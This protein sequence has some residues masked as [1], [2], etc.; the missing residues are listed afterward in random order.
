MEKQIE[1][2]KKNVILDEKRISLDNRKP[3]KGY[4]FNNGIDFSA[5]MR[6][7]ETMGIQSSNMFKAVELIN[8]M[9]AWRGEEGEKCKIYLGYTSNMA[10]SGMREIIRYLCEHSLVDAIVT[11]TGGVEEDF[12]KCL[13]DHLVGEFPEDDRE[14]RKQGINR[15]GNMYVPNV[16]YCYFEDWITPLLDS[17]WTEQKETG[18]NWTPSKMIDFLG[19]NINNK[20]SI[21]YWCHKNKIPVYCPGLTD[22]S[23]GDMLF[24]HSYKKPGL[25]IDVVEDIRKI[26]SSAIFAKQTGAIILGGGIVK[27]H[28]MNANLMRNGADFTVLINTAIEYDC[29][30]AGAKPTEALSWGKIKS[31]GEFVKIYSEASLVFPFIVAE[32][33]AREVEKRKS[34]GK[35]G[36]AKD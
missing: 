17:M 31:S 22:G 2:A 32:T 18:I 23:I 28:I 10:S 35:A 25:I 1:D 14:L 29:S 36:E 20:D 13:A 3:V 8:K 21:Y 12:M 33:F 26:N 16:N 34:E 15:I 9:L 6:S 11:T 27:H 4:D 24:F 7:S 5:I 19:K 30:D